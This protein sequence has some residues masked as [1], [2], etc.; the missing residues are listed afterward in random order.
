MEK[1]LVL[2]R[3]N[4]DVS[5]VGVIDFPVT[6]YN[7][8]AQNIASDGENLTIKTL[9]N[10]G[11]EAHT[12]LHHIIQNWDS[13]PELTIFSQANP[14]EHTTDFLDRLRYNYRETTSLTTQHLPHHPGPRVRSLDRVQYVHGHEVRYGM[15]YHFNEMGY[16]YNFNWFDRLWARLF[17]SD[18]KPESPIFGYAAI[19]AVPRH[20]ITAR[21]KSF[22]SY[23]LKQLEVYPALINPFSLE[24]VWYY[25]WADARRYPVINRWG[26]PPL[27]PELPHYED[28]GNS[29][30]PK[31]FPKIMI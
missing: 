5:W 1:E 14:F 21:P 23:C 20:R 16:H 2:A 13:L 6:I 3:Y 19:W 24:A 11:R 10:V 27:P 7:K 17:E 15:V 8:G 9:Y 29:K 31:R 18:S 25:I 4:E 28:P 12:Y 22:Y 26:M 30:W